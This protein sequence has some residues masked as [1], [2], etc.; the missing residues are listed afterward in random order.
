MRGKE[1]KSYFFKVYRNVRTVT[2]EIDEVIVFTDEG[3]QA[4][5]KFGLNRG[6]IPID[7]DVFWVSVKTIVVV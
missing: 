4:I 2:N 1:N 6:L 7:T 5:R 3:K